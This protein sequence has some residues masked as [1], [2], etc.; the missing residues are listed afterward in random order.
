MLHPSDDEITPGLRRY[1][2]VGEDRGVPKGYKCRN[3]D[4]WWRPPIVAP[5]DL[6]FT[7]MSHRYPRL[8]RNSAKVSFVNSMHGVR[9]STEAPAVTA[10]ALPL[11]V[12]NSVSMLGAEIHGR[13]YGGGVLKMEPSEAASLPVPGPGAMTAAFERLKDDRASLSRQLEGG[14]WKEVVKRVDE[15][16]LKDV[17]GLPESDLL[18]LHD[19]AVSLRERRIGRDAAPIAA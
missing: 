16:L 1:L 18:A 17:L 15:V 10:P 14:R 8:I 7:Y 19:A 6:F 5:P 3:R 12:F 4:P 11:L 9:L 13:S 2:K